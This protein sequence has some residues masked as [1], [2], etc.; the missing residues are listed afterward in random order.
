MK[1]LV[2]GATGRVGANL[3]K[4]LTDKGYEIRAFV[5][6]GDTKAEILKQFNAEIFE[7]DFTNYD[8]CVKAVKGMDAVEHLGAYYPQPQFDEVSRKRAQHDVD[9]LCFK[10]NIQGTFYLLEATHRHCPKCTRFVFA[11]SDAPYFPKLYSPT[12]EEHPMGL[13]HRKVADVQVDKLGQ[14]SGTYT[15]SKVIGEDM[16]MEYYTRRGLP[17]TSARFCLVVGPNEVDSYGGWMLEPMLEGLKKQAE[18]SKEDLDKIKFLEK[19]L[20][21]GKT[22]VLPMTEDGKTA[23]RQFGDPRDIALGCVCLLESADAV[24]E[25]FNIACPP[26]SVG[27]AVKH[28]AKAY[29]TSYA[30]TIIPNAAISYNSIAKARNL[31]GFDPKY[32]IK[33]MIDDSARIKRGEP[34]DIILRERPKIL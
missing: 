30:T 11:S 18:K 29:E 28:A 8:D 33:K 3:I 14:W 21:E 25:A 12:D 27:E 19:S 31:A 20:A 7:G 23:I 15:T 1:V 24:G 5:L 22:L 32:D 10:V 6:P 4:Q 17:T 16:A 2:T 9:M 26:F 13:R 34:V